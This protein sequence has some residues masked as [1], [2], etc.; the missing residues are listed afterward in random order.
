MELN[1]VWVNILLPVLTILIPVFTTIYT[2]NRRVENE[3][4]E[5]HKPY[6][7]LRKI[8]KIKEL[9]IYSYHLLIIGRNFRKYNHLLSDSEV[10]KFLPIINK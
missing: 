8:N 9:D 4:K 3:N 10:T 2:V 6:L 7:V 1:E 5:S